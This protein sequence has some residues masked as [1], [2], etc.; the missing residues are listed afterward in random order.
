MNRSGNLAASTAVST[1]LLPLVLLPLALVPASSARAA[2]AFVATLSAN[3]ESRTYS[4]ESIED[5]IDSV[6]GTSLRSLLP[7]YTDNA[8][9]TAVFNLR[10]LGATIEYPGAGADLVLKVPAAG[11]ERTFTGATRDEAE[12]ALSDYFKGQGASDVTSILQAAVRETAIDPVAGNPDSLMSLMGAADFAQG[13]DALG[14]SGSEGGTD[15]FGFTVEGGRGTAPGG[16]DQDRVT[17]AL[18]YRMNFEGS[19]TAVLFDLPVN[20]IRTGESDSLSGSLGI[21]VRV[22]L[23]DSWS[24]TP[25]V[26]AGVAGSIDMGAAAVVYSGSLTSDFRWDWGGWRF[27]L[28]NM[29]GVYRATGVSVGDYDID[30]DLTN[31][32]LRNGVSVSRDLTD[33]VAPLSVT[34][35]FVDSRYLGDDLFVE[36]FDEV[37]V[38]L[39]KA[40]TAGRFRFDRVELGVSY[41][42]GDDYERIM[43]KLK[44]RF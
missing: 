27:G 18:S 14:H 44:L 13:T 10:G 26:R 30:Y 39:A 29:A 16:Y 6:S 9:A 4:Y 28:G 38:S 25:A 17:G 1:A 19:D 43:G 22:P 42:F 34:A 8:P 11:I 23:T 35:S 3:G 37:T 40:A 20:W 32:I 21:G 12:D 24:L 33:S 5:A 15:L 41:G 36:A 7:S 2:D 31:V